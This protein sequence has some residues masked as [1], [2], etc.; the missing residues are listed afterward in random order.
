MESN[1]PRPEDVSD[2]ETPLKKP[3]HTGGCIQLQAQRPH[4]PS[5]YLSLSRILHVPP[6]HPHPPFPSCQQPPSIP[7][8]LAHVPG[9]ERE[10]E[11]GRSAVFT[12]TAS[13]LSR[14]EMQECAPILFYVCGLTSDVGGALCFGGG[15][16][17]QDGGRAFRRYTR[18]VFFILQDGRYLVQRREH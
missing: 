14:E 6:L 7:I 3:S 4:F 1:V 12:E 18:S 16:A 15:P 13:S 10:R 17:F 5:L 11:G 8:T 2:V 9:T